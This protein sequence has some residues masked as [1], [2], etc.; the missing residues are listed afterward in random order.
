MS[1]KPGPCSSLN[2]FS[3][4]G[5]RFLAGGDYDSK[6]VLWVSKLTTTKGKELVNFV[7]DNN[8]S[9]ISSGTLTYWP[10]A[11]EQHPTFNITS[12]LFKHGLRSGV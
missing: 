9:Y 7:Q 5:Q 12:I 2:F 1:S 6:N 4:L 8:Y 3:T 10:T 11:E